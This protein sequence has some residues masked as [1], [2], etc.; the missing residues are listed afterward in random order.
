MET[1]I[2]TNAKSLLA[3][4]LATENITI[5]QNAN[6]KTA[7]FDVKNRV[8]ELPIWK[9]ISEDLRDLLVVHEV[10]HALDTPA[11]GWLD[12]IDHIA[13][14][15]HGSK[16]RRYVMAVKGF[17]N[18]VEDARIDKRQKRRYP[19]TRRNYLA[20]YKELLERDFFRIKSRD[21]NS[22]SFI[23][24]AN[25]YFKGGFQNLNIQFSP[26]ERSLLKRMEDTETFED[27][28]ALT[29]ELYKLARQQGEDQQQEL[30]ADD[31]TYG[32]GEDGDEFEVFESDEDSD[33]ED[34][35]DDGEDGDA[36]ADTDFDDEDEE[37]SENESKSSRNSKDDE[38]EE[39][40][41]KNDSN[42]KSEQGHSGEDD[43][44]PKSE[45]D[46]AYEENR[47]LLADDSIH[48]NYLT[49]PKPIMSEIVHDYKKFLAD[50]ESFY[51]SEGLA[52]GRDAKWFAEVV[53]QVAKFRNE[54]N[55]TIS[56]MVKEFEQRKS[57]D[58][59]SRTSI[60]K[61]GVIDTNKLHSYRYNDD[62]FRRLSIVPQG[63]NH[64][65]IMFVDWSGSMHPNLKYTIRQLMSLTMFCKRVQIPFEVYLFRE[66]KYSEKFE[67]VRGRGVNFDNTFVLRNVLSS[68]MNA[69]ELNRAYQYLW[70]AGISPTRC[71]PMGGT[72]LNDAIYVADE[73][74]NTFRAKYKLQ[75]VNTIFLTD[76]DSNSTHMN[77]NG[78]MF[79]NN[80]KKYKNVD[81]IQDPKTKKEYFIED[82]YRGFTATLFKMLKDRTGCNLVGFYLF[83]SLAFRSVQWR[84]NMGTDPVYLKKL[85]TSWSGDN[86]IPVTS[87]G[88][89]EYYVINPKSFRETAVPEKL[90]VDSNMTKAKAARAFLK[91][92]EKKAINRLLLNR[93]MEKVAGKK[94]N[95]A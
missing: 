18:V 20:G 61:T 16:D 88:Y 52:R 43:F 64:G 40:E 63:K 53:N 89:D 11:D 66:H 54:E 80:G 45:T 50:H 58:I 12:A 79:Y 13:Q 51:K 87:E 59:Y 46:E 3:K 62:I 44:I 29:E 73:L 9:G 19:G 84:F 24:R 27:V 83:D 65:F 26:S 74:V 47:E 8:L 10:G 81:V 15:E 48:Y 23:D 37:D 75:V 94:Q 82:R 32:E 95:A 2:N 77:S 17:L 71:E 21:V 49:L 6:A 38:D 14:A 90:D 85:Q 7:S 70:A 72:P 60:A 4:L 28:I 76:G 91:Y 86:F 92:A 36:D 31:F 55:A 34:S 30:E 42:S 57:A 93:F 1:V 39:N 69:S 67:Q 41:Q 22:L 33:D 25:V 56:Y 78:S 68:R 5:R 35:D